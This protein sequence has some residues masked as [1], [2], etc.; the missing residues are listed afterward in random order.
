MA[1]VRGKAKDATALRAAICEA[2]EDRIDDEV[3]WSQ[4]RVG[5]V[6]QNLARLVL[7]VGSTVVVGLLVA[8]VVVGA[9]TRNDLLIALTLLVVFGGGFV[10]LV[11]AVDVGV[12]VRADGRLIRSGWGGRREYDLRA[13]RRVTVKV[14]RAGDPFVGGVDFSGE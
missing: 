5:P 14:P 6:V 3:L 13:Y 11:W 9:E 1:G 7:G 12:E 10:G 4:P 8:L 2:R